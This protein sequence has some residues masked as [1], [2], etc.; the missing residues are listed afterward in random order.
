MM[1][2]FR[3]AER[4]R[5]HIGVS[6]LLLVLT[7]ACSD[8]AGLGEPCETI[9]DCASE[10]Q[11][12]EGTCLPRCSTH[13]DCGDGYTCELGG[14]CALVSSELGDPCERE[15]DCAPGQA[16][17]LDASDGDGDGVLAARC[18]ADHPGAPIGAACDGDDDCRN[19]TCAIGRCVDLCL[20]DAD[21]PLAQAC[22]TIPRLLASSEPVFGGC[23]QRD[24]VLVHELSVNL[25]FES[26][27]V[28]VPSTARSFAL[29]VQIDNEEQFAGA[30]RVVAP[31]GTVLYR[32]TDDFYANPLRYSPALGISTMLLPNTPA[33]AIETGA[34]HI[35]VGSFLPSGAVATSVPTVTAHY[36]LDDRAT[37]DLNYH[38]LDLADHPCAEAFPAGGL[39]A[40]GA[41]AS[42]DFQGEYLAS[43]RAILAEAE[44]DV[45]NVTYTDILDQP[46]LDGLDV[47]DLPSL[48]KEG[49]IEGGL[50]VYFVRTIAPAG[51]Q[52]LVGGTPGP[53]GIPGTRASGIVLAADTLCYRDWVTMARLTAHEIGRHA[54]LFR[55]REPDGALDPIDDSDST[56]A[57]LMYYSE[58]GGIEVSEGQKQV[59]RRFPGLR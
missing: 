22:A 46:T 4:A 43:L 11:C 24:G 5:A 39:D 26:L 2:A 47:D 52:G 45:G 6:L 12:L 50:N 20:A 49:T 35:D 54:G 38:F 16:C 30:A 29:V 25:P 7:A 1:G 48:L 21:C 9:D 55:N 17:S 8:G 19:G 44:I 32:A 36:K 14:L 10:L 18:A 41:A 56:A 37:L 31:D 42:T 51:L 23:L 33:L 53:P 59:L 57:N 13:A 28:P 34:Y 40:A 58:F 27:R 15:L 3:A